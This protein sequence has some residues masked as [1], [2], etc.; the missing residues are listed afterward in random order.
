[1]MA[2]KKPKITL[3]IPV[4]NGQKKIERCLESLLGQTYK[5]I[6]IIVVNNGSTDNTEKI[7]REFMKEDK[8]IKLIQQP[9]QGPGP[10]KNVAAKQAKG[11]VL[12]FIDSD[13]YLHR[14]YIEKLTKPIIS[15]KSGTSIGSWIIA[16]PKNPWARCRYKNAHKFRQHAVHSGV[17]RAIGRKDFLKSG[18][19][20]PSKGIS[21][22]RLTTGLK[23]VRVD[24]AIF[25]HDVD[26]TLLENYKKRK[27][28]GESV[29]GNPKGR[30]F[31]MK[32]AFAFLFFVFGILGIIASPFLLI[33]VVNILLLF[34]IYLSLKK[35][36]SYKD[37]RLLF[38]YPV[39][40]VVTTF[41]MAFGLTSDVLRR[42]LKIK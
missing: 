18:G 28:I 19:F 15:G 24:D 39:Y 13:E 2:K 14:D 17:F 26:N 23:R 38:Y 10:A 33:V 40:L 3:I 12:V 5:N 22:D 20:D 35:V 31:K 21:D 25:D 7:I 30:K 42:L 29:I 36:F 11:D 37:S 32:I 6:E 1:M 9:K 8:K 34:I 4:Y 41:A 27:W 16:D